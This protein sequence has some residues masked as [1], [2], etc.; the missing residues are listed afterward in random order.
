MDIDQ[1][2]GLSSKKCLK[3]CIEHCNQLL[4]GKTLGGS[5]GWYFYQHELATGYEIK[6]D[7]CAI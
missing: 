7:M 1:G 2:L 5:V 3:T 4:T 6:E